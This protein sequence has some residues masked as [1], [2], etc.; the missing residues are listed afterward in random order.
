MTVDEFLQ[1]KAG[2]FGIDWDDAGH[3]AALESVGEDIAGSAMAAAM[4]AGDV[5]AA[6]ALL[7]LVNQRI[8][9][10]AWLRRQWERPSAP[11]QEPG[12]GPGSRR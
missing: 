9:Q 3:L 11:R 5:T 1:A 6:A 2:A 4:N 7:V 8:A 12:T 10:G